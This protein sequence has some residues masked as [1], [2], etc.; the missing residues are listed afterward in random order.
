MKET[1]KKPGCGIQVRK[2]RMNDHL[3][4]IHGE[5]VETVH[6]IPGQLNLGSFFRKPEQQVSDEE[7][8]SPLN[9][10]QNFFERVQSED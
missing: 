8:P 7:I 1:C 5:T 6:L 3:K 9:D 2:D 10:D 4:N